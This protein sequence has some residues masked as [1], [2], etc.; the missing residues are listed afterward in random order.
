MIILQPPLEGEL[1]KWGS[2]T[3]ILAATLID[4]QSSKCD[5]YNPQRLLNK[6]TQ[7]FPQFAG[8]EQHDSHEILRHLLEGVRTEDLKVCTFYDLLFLNGG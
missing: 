2:L 4:L 8:G 3:E 6:L 1:G 7:R 5:V